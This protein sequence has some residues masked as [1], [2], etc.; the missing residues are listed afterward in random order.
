MPGKPGAFGFT[1]GGEGAFGGGFGGGGGGNFAGGG[2]GGYSGG[3]AGGLSSGRNAWGGGGGGSFASSKAVSLTVSTGHYESGLVFIQLLP[4]WR[5]AS[6]PTK[7]RIHSVRSDESISKRI[8]GECC[9]RRGR[10]LLGL[11]LDTL[12][13]GVMSCHRVWSWPAR[14]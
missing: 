6:C 9:G 10:C 2:G 11:S 7:D 5:D 13:M 8:Q 4:D 14:P 12:F 1:F 3:A